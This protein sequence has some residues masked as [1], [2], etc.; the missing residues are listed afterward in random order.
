MRE[1]ALD[2]IADR[3]VLEQVIRE[4]FL[5]EPRRLPVVDVADTQA[6]GVDLLTHQRFPFSVVVRVI[7]MWLV[8]FLIRVARPSARGR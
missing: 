8:R 7:V 2:V 6:L 1:L 5:V 4:L 3:D